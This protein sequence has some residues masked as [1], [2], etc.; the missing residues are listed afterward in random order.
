MYHDSLLY[1]SDNLD[2]PGTGLSQ[3]AARA[4]PARPG[5]RAR[6]PN[7]PASLGVSVSLWGSE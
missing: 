4:S 1:R 7:A 5:A 3:R 2:G 6:R